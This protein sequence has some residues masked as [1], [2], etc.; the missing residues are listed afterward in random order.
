M[1]SRSRSLNTATGASPRAQLVATICCWTPTRSVARPTGEPARSSS[2]PTWSSWSNDL[3]LNNLSA[4]TAPT[5][6][7]HQLLLQRWLHIP[8][9]STTTLILL[10][11]GENW[12]TFF[13]FFLGV[14]FFEIVNFVDYIY[15]YC[16]FLFLFL[17][18]KNGWRW[19]SEWWLLR[20][21][22]VMLV[23]KLCNGNCV[24]DWLHLPTRSV[25]LWSWILWRFFLHPNS[26]NLGKQHDNYDWYGWAPGTLSNYRL[27]I[28]FFVVCSRHKIVFAG[29]VWWSVWTCINFAPHV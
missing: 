20:P 27:S 10:V 28:V 25:V 3:V 16:V 2:R 11:D 21:S 4:P 24:C 6:L 1:P 17:L 19:S 8:P 13:V 26:I 9:N 14:S 29:S 15:L 5:R 12:K 23:L 22:I 18:G 7:L